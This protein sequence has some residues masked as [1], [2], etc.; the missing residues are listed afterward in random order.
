MNMY[1]FIY[2]LIF[3]FTLPLPARALDLEVEYLRSLSHARSNTEVEKLQQSYRQLKIAQTACAIQ[4]K[5]E[6]LPFTC[7][8]AMDLETRLNMKHSKAKAMAKTHRLD[9]LCAIAAEKFRL[10]PNAPAVS[11]KCAQDIQSARAIQIYR[12]E[13]SADWNKF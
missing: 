6:I 13:E 5:E 4:L 7:Y 10:P 8:E 3:C 11:E 9:R 1:A 12:E 2:I